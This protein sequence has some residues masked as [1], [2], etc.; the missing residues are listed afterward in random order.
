MKII[1]AILLLS[2]I[3]LFH[4]LGHFL[5]AK[6]NHIGVTE[7]SL[8]MGPRLF[9]FERGGTRYSLKLLPFGGSCAMLG[10]DLDDTQPGAFSAAPVWGRIATVAA[11]P[12]FNFILA[13]VLATLIVGLY[14]SGP[15][16]V[17]MVAE[18][19]AAMKAGLQEGDLI[20][21]FQGHKVDLTEELYLYLYLNPLSEEQVS[22]K[23]R[24]DGQTVDI[25]YEPDVNIRYLMGYYKDEENA[26]LVSSVIPGMGMEDAG[27]KAGDLITA[28]NGTAVTGDTLDAYLSENPLSEEP[29][30]ITY[31]RDGLSYEVSV[32]P[33]E[34][35]I[36]ILGFSTVWN[37]KQSGLSIFKYG[38]L[39]LKYTVKSTILGLKELFTGKLSV[40]EMSGPVGVVNVV[41]ETY[42]NSKSEGAFVVLLNMMN[43]VVL[44]S[45]NL[46]VMN[47]L[48]IPGLDGGR[49]IFLLIEAIRRKPGNREL[50]G[51]INVA[52][53]M[54]LLGFMVFILYNDIAKLF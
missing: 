48:P 39:E 9:S 40:K 34:D 27:I 7:F 43:L 29:V 10:E 41:G 31:E 17:S 22:L 19:S 46:G 11:G 50:E 2:A 47:L 25:V 20:T 53:V 28:I 54:L 18:D 45:A 32:T 52:G 51:M 3:V 16:R 1:I 49:L 5:L 42:E 14:G 36:P 33:G 12:V 6:A 35:R 30:T 24:R 38:F 8:G 13:F 44:L 23:V 26:A 15:S 4:E 37:E 21:S